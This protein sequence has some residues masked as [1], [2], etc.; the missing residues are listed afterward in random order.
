V[1]REPEFD[2]EFRGIDLTQNHMFKEISCQTEGEFGDKYGTFYKFRKK[3]KEK[4]WN[5]NWIA[6][7]RFS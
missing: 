4:I 2:S 6:Q 3:N 7:I 5:V 1:I